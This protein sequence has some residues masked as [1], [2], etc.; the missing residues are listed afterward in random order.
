MNTSETPSWWARLILALAVMAAATG[1]AVALFLW[2]LDAV[3]RLRFDH[4]WLLYALP[5]AGVVV[6]GLYQWL[7]RG[8]EGGN[9]LL[10]DQIHEPG[11]GVPL[12]MAPLILVTT[13]ITHLC[14]GSAG[15]EGTAV[16]MGGS[17]A[18]GFA[19]WFRLEG[20]ALRLLLMAGIAA[21]FGA[22]FGTPL[23]G[24]VFAAEVLAVGHLRARALAPC[25]AAALVGDWVCH[26]WGI[27]HTVYHVADHP[28]HLEWMLVLKV[29]LASAAFGLA[30][31]A[32]V[33]LSHAAS[34]GW[35]K[36]CPSVL[37]RPVL[38]AGVIIALTA[39][40]GTR[41][42]L[43][44]GVWSVEPGAAVIPGF[45][46]AD[47][48]HPWAWA[49]KLVFTVITLSS[50]FKG[51]EVTPLFFIGAGL[52]HALAGPLAAPVDLM[53]GLGFIA[54]FAG[55]TNTP[56]ACTLMGVELFGAAN[57]PWFAIAC[58]TARWCSGRGGIYTAQRAVGEG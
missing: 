44:L 49:W 18:G 20:T 39:V 15:R 43:G 25:L 9:N 13:I 35:K 33:R 48:A 7:G 29:L 41:D 14:G 32:F 23:A 55:A 34:T 36:V 22:V 5:V 12:K 56:L 31:A 47:P 30:A 53:A 28:V 27:G 58:F 17:L 50:G 45:F 57:A 4:P 8:V 38:A 54:V 24:T 37:L 46:A 40:L 10:I 26:A 51:G 42:Y 21:G 16:Q 1:S 3:T 2:S 6:A 19:Q 11:G 52:G